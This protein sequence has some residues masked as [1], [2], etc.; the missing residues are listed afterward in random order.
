MQSV[1]VS[2]GLSVHASVVALPALASQEGS[3]AT[4]PL[5]LLHAFLVLSGLAWATVVRLLGLLVG[6]VQTPPRS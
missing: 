2:P 6:V 5:A 1:F 3:P 4:L